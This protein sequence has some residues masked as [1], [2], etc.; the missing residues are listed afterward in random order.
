MKQISK[1]ICVYFCSLK[2]RCAVRAANFRSL[3]VIISDS[4]YVVSTFLVISGYLKYA[5]HR[6]ASALELHEVSASGI[7]PTR[8][9]MARAAEYI[10]KLGP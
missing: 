3:F 6:G 7:N 4:Y 5:M 1:H 10:Y 8:Q 9:Q 2:H